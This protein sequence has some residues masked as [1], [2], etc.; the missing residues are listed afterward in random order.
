M[1]KKIKILAVFLSITVTV[2]KEIHALKSIAAYYGGLEIN[3]NVTKT[4]AEENLKE[5]LTNGAKNS[6]EVVFSVLHDACT[7]GELS[8]PEAVEA[9]KD[10]LARNA[11]RFYKISSTNITAP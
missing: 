11:I 6:R 1:E 8:I 7:D 5:V 10:I 9:A 2:A 3:L 4:D